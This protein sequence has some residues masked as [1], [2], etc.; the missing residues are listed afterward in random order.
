MRHF[1]TFIKRAKTQITPHAGEDV[2]QQEL[3][4]GGDKSGTDHLKTVLQFL[5]KLRS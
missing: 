1:C 2:K 4:F 5:T 3:P